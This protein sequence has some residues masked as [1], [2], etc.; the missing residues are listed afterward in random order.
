MTWNTGYCALGDNPD[1]FMDH[2][3]QVITASRDR[4]QTNLESIA[5]EI[6]TV[7]PD[8]LFLQEVDRNSDRSYKIDTLERFYEVLPAHD[9]TFAANYRVFFVPFP[10]PPIGKVDSGIA[11]LSR[12]PLTSSARVSLPCPF[13]WPVRLANLK[14]CL[15]VSR[16]P[17]S[18]SDHELILINLH[19]EAYDNGTGKAAQTAALRRIM[20]MELDKG[21]YLIVGGDFNQVFSNVD[22]SSYP[23]YENMWQPGLIDIADFSD[24]YS[25]LMDNA[26]PTCRSLDR[27]YAGADPASFQFYM[28]DGFILSS[29]IRVTSLK[30]LDLDFV[31]S[32]HNPVLLQVTLLP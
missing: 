30:T 28:I 31:A 24:H 26:V 22:T 4:V 12:F 32:D 19:L 10:I 11:T 17:I 29:N 21:N 13:S 6:A 16:I 14:R 5:R 15:L 9:Q 8:I 23:V 1:F 20:D 3:T 7:S 2:G 18:D 25:F 27:P